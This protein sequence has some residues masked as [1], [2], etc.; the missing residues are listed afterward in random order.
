V[1]VA[2]H[3]AKHNRHRVRPVPFFRY[4]DE[5]VKFGVTKFLGN[6]HLSFALLF[7]IPPSSDEA[8]HEKRNKDTDNFLSR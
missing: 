2:L 8:A 7:L 1:S 6:H 3:I 4:A 5:V